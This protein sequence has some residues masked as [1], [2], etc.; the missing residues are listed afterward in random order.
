MPRVHALEKSATKQ[1]SL[2]ISLDKEYQ[3]ISFKH[4]EA[5]EYC[6]EYTFLEAFKTWE[7]FIENLFI[8]HARYNDP[9]SGR[10]TYPFLAPRTEKHALELLTLERDYLDW[11]SPDNIISRAETC[12]RAHSV[13]TTPIKRCIQDLRDM[14]KIRNHIAH[15]SKETGRI[16]KDL[17][18]R[19]LGKVVL[20]PG[21]YLNHNSPD[22]TNNYNV[23]YLRILLSLT[24]EMAG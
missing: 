10:R 9:V 18:R 20:R 1:L 7:N 13:I 8:S 6:I 4:K 17:S 3:S 23:Y 22:G 21:N 19:R 14:K 24:N 12:F 11:T 5:L 2:L 15:G 16:F